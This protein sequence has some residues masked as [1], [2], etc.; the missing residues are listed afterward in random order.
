M[1]IIIEFLS[2]A[3]KS[4]VYLEKTVVILTLFSMIFLAF[5]QVVS[6][7]IFSYG[8]MSIDEILRIQVL[9]LTFLGACLASE[10]ARHIQIDVLAHFLGGGAATK[11]LN[12]L[13][14]VVCLGV[15]L[16]LA[17]AAIDYINMVAASGAEPSPIGAIPMWVFHLVIPYAF[18]AMGIR[19]L[20][21]I[22]RI[23][24]GN[25]SRSIEP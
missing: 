9:W 12:I 24:T 17:R 5:L 15:C 18:I 21:N 13:A 22:G 20:I 2:Q 6:R 11:V 16:L 19:C 3:H 8:F 7:N 10:Y 23:Y 1:K 4:L 14:Q 25:Y